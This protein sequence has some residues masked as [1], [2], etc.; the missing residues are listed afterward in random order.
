M[1]CNSNDSLTVLDVSNNPHLV[2]LH[3]WDSNLTELWLKE[4]QL[5]VFGKVAKI[6]K[7]TLE[8]WKFV[9]ILRWKNG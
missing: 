9:R 3:C 2:E 6:R 7:N 8:K 1:N 5:L 4:G